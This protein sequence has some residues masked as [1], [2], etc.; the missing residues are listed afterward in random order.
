MLDYRFDTFLTLCETMNYTRA[1][2]KLNLTQPAVTQH[3]RHLENMYNC[4]LFIYK[5]KTLHLT[6]S[7]IR[8]LEFTKSMKYN[9]QKIKSIITTPVPISLKI[10]VS[11]T[12]GEYIIVP[13]IEQFLKL[14]PN[15][16]FSLI[17]ENTQMLLHLLEDG[18]IDFAIIEGFF[19]RCKYDTK[20][21]KK[22][23]FLGVCSSNN[24][25]AGR[26]VPINE[27]L[28]ERLILREKGS[29]TRAIFE[30]A[31]HLKN[32][33]I[34][35]FQR[36]ITISDF[37]VI[38]SLITKDLGISFLYKPV[39]IKEIAKGEL[40]NFEIEDLTINGAF[41]FVCLKNNLFSSNWIN[42]IE[43]I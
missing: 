9:S 4:K 29:G 28:C 8:L 1:A 22:E 37:S 23:L 39:V 35:N 40:A 14:K 5:G 7:G 30:E 34:N 15:A 38:K 26:K 11:K 27:L 32:Y 3:I 21:Y 25:L 24:P 6:E 41:Y 31:L 42:W 16:K 18:K 10:G 20:L 33:S 17:V 36:I 2:E 13:K 19:D 12:I 43:N